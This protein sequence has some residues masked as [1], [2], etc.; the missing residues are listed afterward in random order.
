MLPTNQ[1]NP[2]EGEKH[3]YEGWKYYNHSIIP[4]CAPHETPNTKCID[5]DIFNVLGGLLIRYTTDFDNHEFSNFWYV[6]KDAPFSMEDLKTKYRHNV[7][8]ALKKCLVKI[9]DPQI[10]ID[11]IIRVYHEAVI[12]YKAPDNIQNDTQIKDF[13]LNTTPPIDVWGAFHY[14]KQNLLIA[15]MVCYKGVEHI[16]TRTAKYATPYLNLRASD[17]IQ[18]AILTHYLNVQNY[19]YICSG[20]RSVNHFSNSQDYK[21]QNWGYRKAHC[22]LHIIYSWKIKWIIRLFYPLRK[23]LLT[24]DNIKTFHHLN[25]ILK[26]EEYSQT[27]HNN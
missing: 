17:A 11:Q 12:R 22:K 21:I 27:Q 6:V 10:Y 2:S 19:K 18:Y 1:A 7:R 20:T 23:L 3:P 15:Y 24:F 26:M 25:A 9:I 8:T 5:N 4:T 16:E 13:F 14:D